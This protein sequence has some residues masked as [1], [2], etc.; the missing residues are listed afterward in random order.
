MC[1]YNSL[2][3][4]ERCPVNILDAWATQK[5]AIFYHPPWNKFSKYIAPLLR[6]ISRSIFDSETAM[7][8]GNSKWDLDV[9]FFFLFYLIGQSLLYWEKFNPALVA[10]P[11]FHLSL[12]WIQILRFCNFHYLPFVVSFRLS[13]I[14]QSRN[15]HWRYHRAIWIDLHIPTPKT[16]ESNYTAS[17][18]MI[19]DLSPVLNHLNPAFMVITIRLDPPRNSYDIYNIFVRFIQRI[20]YSTNTCSIYTTRIIS[21]FKLV[22]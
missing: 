3:R 20:L 1:F 4:I 10:F 6:F 17:L 12:I 9:S 14:P 15:R 19:A 2:E 13:I 21:I 11:S 5:L 22:F 7:N 16:I 8:N 18:V